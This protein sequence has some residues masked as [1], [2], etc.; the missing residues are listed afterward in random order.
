MKSHL[1]INILERV[2]CSPSSLTYMPFSISQNVWLYNHFS[3]KQL[4]YYISNFKILKIRDSSFIRLAI[5]RAL[6]LFLV[7]CYKKRF[8]INSQIFITFRPETACIYVTK[9]DITQ[10]VSCQSSSIFSGVKWMLQRR[11]NGGAARLRFQALKILDW[12]GG[13]IHPV[14]GRLMQKC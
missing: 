13:V 1:P 11:K 6:A 4:R 9:I 10:N 14:N 5:I 7:I 3:R 2:Q 8:L 12:G